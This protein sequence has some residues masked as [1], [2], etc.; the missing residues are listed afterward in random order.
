[1]VNKQHGADSHRYFE[2]YLSNL[3]LLRVA[4]QWMNAVAITLIY[5]KSIIATPIQT[6]KMYSVPESFSLHARSSSRRVAA[7]ASVGPGPRR[8]PRD[9][10]GGESAAPLQRPR[11]DDAARPPR[12][13]QLVWDA[14]DAFQVSHGWPSRSTCRR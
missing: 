10:G 1:M 2:H 14:P 4:R 11:H 5:S 6:M 12:P 13:R 3:I 9:G 7:G 8:P